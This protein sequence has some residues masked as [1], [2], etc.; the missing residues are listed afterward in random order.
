MQSRTHNALN[1]LFGVELAASVADDGV[2][3]RAIC[4]DR[5]PHQLRR[6]GLVH[7]LLEQ[8]RTDAAADF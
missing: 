5:P 4:V 8:G 6:T 7:A 2:V 1:I 3:L